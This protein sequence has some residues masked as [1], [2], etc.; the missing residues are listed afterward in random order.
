MRWMIALVALVVGC[1]DS[2]TDEPASDMG[3]ARDLGSPSDAGGEVCGA[4]IC[5]A[6]TVCCN[7]S[8]SMC[9]PPEVD[10][11]AIACVDMG[12]ADMGTPCVDCPAPPD[13]CRYVGGSCESCGELVC[14]E[15]FCGGFAGMTC[16][17]ASYCDYDSGCGFADEGGVCRPRPSGCSRDCPQVCGCDGNTYCNGCLAA[18]MGVDVLSDGPCE[19]SGDSCGGFA[20]ATCD[21]G[22]WC[23]YGGCPTPDAIGS[24]EPRPMFC[25]DVYDP[26]CGCNGVTYSNSCEAEAAGMNIRSRGECASDR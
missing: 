18:S 7:A 20:G 3:T 24:C 15:E 17:D 10:C 11:P 8:C 12:T 2:H 25:T 26:V 23:D 22:D 16:D 21:R 6:G 1:G 19:S 9:A 4:T 5:G 13:G 14:E